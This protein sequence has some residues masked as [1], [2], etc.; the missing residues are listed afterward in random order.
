ME[1]NRVQVH[2]GLGATSTAP[3]SNFWPPIQPP[4]CYCNIQV[5]RKTQKE[6]IL[7]LKYR[8]FSGEGL[9]TRV[10][11]RYWGGETHLTPHLLVAFSYSTT[12]WI[13]TT[14]M[15]QSQSEERHITKQKVLL[16]VIESN[17]N[18]YKYVYCICKKHTANPITN[19]T[20]PLDPPL[21]TII[22][23]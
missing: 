21:T 17:N 5:G 8:T 7:I 18:Y 11:R 15:Q 10:G 14:R 16:S 19:L 9:P 12:C 2:K 13:L 4:A 23:Y 1:T 20:V 6:R 3:F 22:R